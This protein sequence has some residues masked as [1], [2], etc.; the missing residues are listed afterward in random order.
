MQGYT[1]V[2]SQLPN[3]MTGSRH[4]NN[5]KSRIIENNSKFAN[6]GMGEISGTV[7]FPMLNSD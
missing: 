4:P 3:L 7:L 1:R 6:A 2:E 5:Q